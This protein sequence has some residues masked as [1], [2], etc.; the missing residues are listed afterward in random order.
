MAIR[1]SKQVDA[2]LRAIEK[3]DGDTLA[4]AR[5]IIERVGFDDLDAL[6]AALREF[7]L[8][9]AELAASSAAELGAM[10]YNTWRAEDIGETLETVAVSAYDEGKYMSAINAA[11]K[12]AERGGTVEDM[13]NTLAG[14]IGYTSRTSYGAT[15]FENGRRDPRKPKYA[16]K[17]GAGEVCQFCLMLA[18]RGFAYSKGR[19]GENVH[20]HANCRCTYICSWDK[21][22]KAQG[23]DEQRYYREWQDS[24]DE[25]AR[26]RAE[27]NGTS[28]ESEREAIMD[29]YAKAASAAK[30]K[31][32]T[33]P[34]RTVIA[35]A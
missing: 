24:V 21:N 15:L 34:T 30:S 3:L 25:E 8:P 12:H 6:R 26:E 31:N 11:V 7:L 14:R 19:L 1:K 35:R 28:V 33:A 4:A 5:K 2:I 13:L 10:S 23:Y 16:R 22:P 9:A 27:R 32:R 18:S 20:N 29:R 17:P